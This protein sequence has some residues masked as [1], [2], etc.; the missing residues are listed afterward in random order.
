MYLEL[1]VLAEGTLYHRTALGVG[2]ELEER[3]QRF[4]ESFSIDK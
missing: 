1:I 4:F 2:D 3:T